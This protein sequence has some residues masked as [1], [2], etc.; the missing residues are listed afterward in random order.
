MLQCLFWIPH[1]G[2]GA[3]VVAIILSTSMHSGLFP[4]TRGQVEA[5]PNHSGIEVPSISNLS[6]SVPW[7]HCDLDYIATGLFL[8]DCSGSNTILISEHDF[9][10]HGLEDG[11]V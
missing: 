8:A 1:R 6:T 11:T 5:T 4:T 3:V 9:L 10:Y 2:G 7:N